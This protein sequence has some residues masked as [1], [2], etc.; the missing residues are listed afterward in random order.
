MAHVIDPFILYLGVVLGGFGVLLAL[1]RRKVSPQLIGAL[2]AAAGLGV[3]LVGLGLKAAKSGQL[4]NLYFY[5]FA[6]IALGASLRVITHPRPVY[7]A[8]YFILTILASAG[9]Y[10][11]LS[12]EFMAF[13]LII[14][15]AGAILIT[16]LFVIMLATQAPTE[17]EEEDKG[18]PYDLA[19]RE[20]GIAAVAGF[21]LLA[22]LTTMFARGIPSL[23]TGEE[24]A[25]K[26]RDPDAILAQLP[27]RVERALR[28]EGLITDRERIARTFSGPPE[29]DMKRRIAV[30]A[31]PN[32][33][34]QS[35][36][37]EFID[38]TRR[39]V[40]LP[41]GLRGRNVENLAFDFLNRH[42][43]SIEIAGV[44]LLMAMLG[45]VVLSRRQV[46]LDEEAK[47]Q[48]S[49]LLSTEEQS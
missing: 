22:A 37:D 39:E 47:A 8:L 14:I 15:Y 27:R 36:F 38:A 48:Q 4:P 18:A 30:V 21:V 3:V 20:P 29:I 40:P 44:V 11:I 42:P 43:G 26:S 10:L 25:L 46:E 17:A 6:A 31:E 24:I 33:V 5:V 19:S 45:A 28:R 34:R 7:A 32:P 23:P 35:D 41:E 16:Y 2:L 13:A 9:M 12:A 49:R 1:P